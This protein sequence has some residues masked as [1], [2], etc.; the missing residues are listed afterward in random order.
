[1]YWDSGQAICVLAR[2]INQVYPITEPAVFC[3]LGGAH[4]FQHSL[5]NAQT[6]CA[7]PK[8]AFQCCL[9]FFPTKVP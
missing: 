2:Y 9:V 5:A 7:M 8:A 6:T 4:F 1:M 3:G